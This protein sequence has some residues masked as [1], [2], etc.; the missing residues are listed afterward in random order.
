MATKEERKAF[1][2]Y[3]SEPMDLSIIGVIEHSPM[4]LSRVVSATGYPREEVACRLLDMKTM[5]FVSHSM[6]LTNDTAEAT[7]CLTPKAREFLR[8]GSANS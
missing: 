3:L 1:M 7:F 2:A 4:T 8:Q 6:E 5:G